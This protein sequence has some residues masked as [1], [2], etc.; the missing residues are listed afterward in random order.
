MWGRLREG[1]AGPVPE[2]CSEGPT[3]KQPEER[4]DIRKER[5]VPTPCAVHWIMASGRKLWV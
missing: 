2:V 3:V 1:L 4:L 5:W